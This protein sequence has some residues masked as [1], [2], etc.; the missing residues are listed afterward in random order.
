MW[1]TWEM[2][3]NFKDTT[4]NDNES[5]EEDALEREMRS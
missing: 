3:T 1:M 2:V 5:L 4:G